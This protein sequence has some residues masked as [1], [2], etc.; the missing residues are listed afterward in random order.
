MNTEQLAAIAA[1]A[2][3]SVDHAPDW[4]PAPLAYVL[5]TKNGA[6]H[7]VINDDFGNTIQTLR[8]G[9]DTAVQ[10]VLTMWKDGAL[11]LPS[12]AFRTALLELDPSNAQTELLGTRRTLDSTMYHK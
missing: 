5:L 11:D 6:V 12:Y 4:L 1:S 2:L 8:D 3:T 7:T 10:T 9:S